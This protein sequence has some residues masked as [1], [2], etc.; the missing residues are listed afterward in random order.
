VL[1]ITLLNVIGVHAFPFLIFDWG[2]CSSGSTDFV[3]CEEP[4]MIG[5]A[6]CLGEILAVERMRAGPSALFIVCGSIQTIAIHDGRETEFS[7]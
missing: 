5:K 1:A 3:W 4:M 2:Y 6:G 7:P